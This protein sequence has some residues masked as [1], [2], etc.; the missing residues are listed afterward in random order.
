MMF[1]YKTGKHSPVRTIILKV[2]ASFAH[3]TLTEH[4]LFF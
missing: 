2:R 1:I 4:A 3:Q